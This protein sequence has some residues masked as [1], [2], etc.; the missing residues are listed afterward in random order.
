ME[1][2]L[3]KS[4]GANE[5]GSAGLLADL[6]VRFPKHEFS[7]APDPACRYCKG[8]GTRP[9]RTL[10]S[11]NKIGETLCA[12]VYLGPHTGELMPL[13]AASARKALGELRSAN[14]EMTD[15]NKCSAG[16]EERASGAK[17][18][19]VRSGDWFVLPR[20]TTENVSNK[21]NFDD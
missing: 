11:G 5:L 9:P 8:A 20:W 7:Y 1:T 21:R 18:R 14:T 2:D 12:C 4:G 19:A 3:P 13:I 10:P 6:R 17:R 16:R 15:G